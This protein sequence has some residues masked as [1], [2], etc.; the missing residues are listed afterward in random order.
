MAELDDT[1]SETVVVRRHRQH[2]ASAHACHSTLLTCFII[3]AKDYGHLTIHEL[4]E[5]LQSHHVDITGVA[6]LGEGRR[7]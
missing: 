6:A 7:D 2:G 4:K 1:V 5:M 3:A